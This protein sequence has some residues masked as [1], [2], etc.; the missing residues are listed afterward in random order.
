[1]R[2]TVPV[3]LVLALSAGCVK[4]ISSEER[5]ERA[6]QGMD[7]GT[8]AT[9]ATLDKL[10]CEDTGEALIKARNVNR[11]EAERLT[12]YTELYR[13]LLTRIRTFE[14]AMARNPDLNYREGSRQYVVAKDACIQQK[15]DVGVEFERYVRELVDVPTVQEIK[16]GN[17]LTVA[18]L[19]YDIL[20]EAIETLNPD[21]KETLLVKV[22]AAEKK[23][24]VRKEAPP[25]RR[26]R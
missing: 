17:T 10:N 19:D 23:I 20:R 21:D 3:C 6:T 24:E 8:A 12:G 4:E 9:T 14:E 13:S 7:P 2:W 1:M 11:P 18:R 16:G 25:R 15:A 26:G 22:A 5:L